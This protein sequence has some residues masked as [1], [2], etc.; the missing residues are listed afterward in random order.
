MTTVSELDHT[1]TDYQLKHV[2]W[3]AK[4][5]KLAYA[6]ESEI[7]DTIAAWGFGSC[8][9]FHTELDASFPIEDTQAFIAASDKMIIVAFRGT[10]PKQIK[11]WLTDTNT[12]AAPGPAGNGL[13]HLGFSRA[14]DSVY[15]QIRDAVQ[16]LRDNNQ[17]LWITGH[18]LG[19][20]LAMLESARMY[21]E[22]PSLL[23]DGVYTFGQPRTCDR[24][25]AEPYNRA[26]TSRV[27]RFVNNNDIVPQV[28]PEPVF[29]H[30]DDIRYFDN[31]GRLHETMTFTAGLFDRVQGLTADM[32]APASDGIRDHSM[33]RYLAAIEKN[34]A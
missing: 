3:L 20:A 15:P 18:S 24:F 32:F 25:L 7:R 16:R 4:A 22:D 6:S 10:E 11:D 28:P 23:P 27:F 19:G 21:F 12:L 14:L 13:V 26:F 5:A 33:D 29:H 17:T 9:F 2:Y 31:H 8:E 34:L 30:V 1:V